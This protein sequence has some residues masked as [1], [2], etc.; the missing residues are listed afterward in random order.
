MSQMEDSS[1]FC[2]DERER[3]REEINNQETEP[4]LEARRQPIGNQT[5]RTRQ[6]RT[7][8]EEGHKENEAKNE[9]EKQNLGPLK[10]LQSCAIQYGS[11]QLQVTIYV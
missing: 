3:E 1:G 6:K 11:H 8:T 10:A 5:G 2:C 7:G 4:V 9:H